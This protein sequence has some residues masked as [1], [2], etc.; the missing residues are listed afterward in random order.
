MEQARFCGN[1]G[2]R[3][4]ATEAFCSN[5]GARLVSVDQQEANNGGYTQQ[6]NPYRNDSAQPR[7]PRQPRPTG[8]LAKFSLIEWIMLGLAGLQFILL[9]FTQY[10]TTVW[11]VLGAYNYSFFTTLFNLGGLGAGGVILLL[12]TWLIMVAAMA[13]FVLSILKMF[14]GKKL[15]LGAFTPPVLFMLGSALCVVMFIFVCISTAVLNSYTSGFGGFRITFAAILI[16]IF[17]LA[18]IALRVPPVQGFI[19]K[20]NKKIFG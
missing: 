20:L 19:A 18:G 2:A 15:R 3:C 16:L 10:I 9:F 8:L 14:L 12:L 7:P 1:C 17:G 13:C 6:Q 4:S 5:C 11:S